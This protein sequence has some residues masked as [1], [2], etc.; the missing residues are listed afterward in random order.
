VHNFD[1]KPHEVTLRLTDDNADRLVDLTGDDHALARRKGVH[2]ISLDAF[3]YRWYA[4]GRPEAGPQRRT[5][6]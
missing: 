2:R 1:E 6:S 3:G 4:V 5:G